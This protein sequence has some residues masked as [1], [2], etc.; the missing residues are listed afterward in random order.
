[1]ELNELSVFMGPTS[2]LLV[3]RWRRRR[4]FQRGVVDRERAT[5]VGIPVHEALGLGGPRRDTAPHHFA[6]LL[7]VRAESASH[8]VI[9]I[10]RNPTRVKGNLGPG[11]AIPISIRPT[12][13]LEPRSARNGILVQ[14][15]MQG[16]TMRWTHFG[17]PTSKYINSGA[18]R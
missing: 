16:P 18:E 8:L 9:M 10:G 12:G 11:T 2:T 6:T 15:A 14:T 5:A 7:L 13:S 1:M 3:V 4:W 17:R